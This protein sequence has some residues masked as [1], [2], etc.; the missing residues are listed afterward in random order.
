ML[1]NSDDL[2]KLK[3]TQWCIKEAMR[4]YPPVHRMFRRLT[5]DTDICGYTVPEGN[6]YS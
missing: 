4:M 5:Q 1:N 3:Y 6:Y 2:S